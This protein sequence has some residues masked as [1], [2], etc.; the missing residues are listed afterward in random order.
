MCDAYWLNSHDLGSE[1]IRA[2]CRY[3]GISDVFFSPHF[4]GDK[5]GITFCQSLLDIFGDAFGKINCIKHDLLLMLIVP[6]FDI[7]AES[8]IPADSLI[9][10]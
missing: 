5:V 7:R 4:P 8:L 1:T 6:L 2:H 10:T 3:G 9:H